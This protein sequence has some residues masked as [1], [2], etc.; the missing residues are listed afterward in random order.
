MKHD[1]SEVQ[2]ALTG[3]ATT[4]SETI[5]DS[6]QG[7][8]QS[9]NHLLTSATEAI[10]SSAADAEHSLGNLSLTTGEAIRNSALDAERS[11]TGASTGVTTAMKQN[12]T[13]MERSLT[14]LAATT[15]EALRTT[16]DEANRKIAATSNDVTGAIKR[17]T[18]EAERALTTVASGVTTA[19]KQNAGEVERALLGVSAEVAR[20]LTAKAE[21]LTASINQRGTD[22]KRVL[23]DKTGVFLSTFGAQGQRFSTEIERISLAAVQSLDAKAVSFAKTLSQSGEEITEQIN[24][25]SSRATTQITRTVGDLDTTARTAIERSQKAATA[26]VTEMMETHGMLRN[27]TSALFERLREANVLLQEV[28]GGATENLSTIETTLSGR[29]A[30]FVNV[31]NEVGDRSGS[32][33]ARF[34]EKMKSFLAGTGGMLRDVTSAADKFDVQSRALADAA[35][36]IDG[37]NRRTEEVLQD[38]H[39]ALDSVVNQIDSKVGDLDQRLKRF[40]AL[41]QET[42][43]TA[44]GRARDISR[45]LAESST[46]GTKAIANQYELVRTTSDEERKRTTEALTSIYE[47]A[48]GETSTLFR[49][50]SERF[51]EIVRQMREMSAAMQREM[52]Q[53]RTELRRGI[54]ELPQETAESAAQMRRV[55]VEQMDALAELNRIV[56]RHGSTAAEQ[57][58]RQPMVAGGGRAEA[59]PPPPRPRLEP[60]GGRGNPPPPRRSEPPPQNGDGRGGWLTDLLG[61][62]SRD[63]APVEEDRQARQAIESLDSLSVDI[64]RMIDHDAAAELWDRYKRGERNVFTRRLY[65]M[66]GQ[67]TF[68]EIRKRYRADR[69]FKST[70]DRYIGEFERLLSEYSQDERGQAT[71]RGY[72]TS[73]TGKVYTMLAHAA[74]RI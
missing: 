19:L 35:K 70:V 45:V 42:F 47:Q 11:L 12:A 57:P 20:G 72:L 34:E 60:V 5:R 25:A 27:D 29:V 55:I 21:E 18:T 16:A 36:Q 41:L 4:V 56:A 43:E 58:I 24:D 22:L 39:E 30:Q 49:Q 59:P 7:V 14:Q 37:S 54:L 23:D 33:S 2:N 71:A 44:E 65:T 26:A 69:D 73:D 63:E 3:L 53:T 8:E 17:G 52:E 74:G 13:E 64:A 66:Q 46:E 68:E 10:R 50:T 38:R 62:A 67:K 6:S 40:A 48:S 1:A 9:L 32:V 28:L 51:V 31:M 61:R 15:A